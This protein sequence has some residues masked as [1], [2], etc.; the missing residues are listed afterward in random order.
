MPAPSSIHIHIE[1][2]VLDGIALPHAQ[3]PLLQA[4]LE[5]EL[6]RLLAERGLAD[7]LASGIQ[8]PSLRSSAIPLA[9]PGEPARLGA[10]IAQSVYGSL[11][12]STSGTPPTGADT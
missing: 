7:G 6:A 9:H 5:A 8:V 11:G 2:L 12:A 3:R 10:Q 1:R 4:A